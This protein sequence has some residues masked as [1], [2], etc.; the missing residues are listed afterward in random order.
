M[1]RI[2]DTSKKPPKIKHTG[3]TEP[4]IDVKKVAKALG[5]DV[6]VS[7]PQQTQDGRS[8]RETIISK[9]VIRKIKKRIYELDEKNSKDYAILITANGASFWLC[10]HTAANYVEDFWKRVCGYRFA[11]PSP[12]NA[13]AV[14]FYEKK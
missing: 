12:G 4:L 13:L 3:K 10:A 9:T 1:T 8:Y 7:G 11:T 5:A 14:A 2:R 6:V